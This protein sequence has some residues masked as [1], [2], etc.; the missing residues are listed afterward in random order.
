M[1]DAR[2][3]TLKD[4]AHQAD[5]SVTTAS[6]SFKPES[7][8][9]DRT[10]ERVLAVAERL[11]YVPNRAARW[12]RQ[13]KSRTIGLLIPHITKPSCA[14]FVRDARQWARAREYEAVFAES[15]WDPEEEGNAIAELVEMRVAGVLLGLLTEANHDILPAL[16]ARG[17]P[18]VVMDTAPTDYAGNFVGNDLRLTGHMAAAHL[19]DVGCRRPVF[20]S[21]RREWT[22]SSFLALREGF[23]SCLQEEGALWTDEPIAWGGLSMGEGKEAATHLME[24][25]PGVDGIFALNDSCAYGV[26]EALDARGIRPGADVA[27]IGL[28]DLPAS[29]LSRISLTTMRQPRDRMV[30]IAA[31]ALIDLVEGKRKAPVREALAPELVV[32]DSTRAFEGKTEGRPGKAT[33]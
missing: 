20:I 19:L 10:R 28:D 21:G 16:D 12:L 18:Y 4:V 11:D 1:S 22:L 8:I 5:V 17:I 9:S 30:K 23:L 2:Q 32:R 13:K 6:L 25:M 24:T 7:R 3:A 15:M 31:G 26:M 33:E 27:L 14:R 29:G